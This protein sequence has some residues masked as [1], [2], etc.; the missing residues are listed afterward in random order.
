MATE[1]QIAV[2]L[3]EKKAKPMHGTKDTVVVFRNSQVI[4]KRKRGEILPAV[5]QEGISPRA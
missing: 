1:L 4:F 5:V 3:G 2:I